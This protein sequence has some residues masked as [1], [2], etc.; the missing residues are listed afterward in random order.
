MEFRLVY[1]G[2]LPSGRS[3]GAVEKHRIREAL[4]P[5][6][7]AL[8]ARTALARLLNLNHPDQPPRDPSLLK[9]VGRVRFLPVISQRLRL[10]AHVDI[11]L[12]RP[13]GAGAV[14]TSGGDLDNRLKTLFDAL[15]MPKD[16]G[17][18]TPRM[19]EGLGDNLFYCLLEDDALI[20]E[21]SVRADQLL[22]P[23]NQDDVI[24]LILV[25]LRATEH[26]WENQDLSS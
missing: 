3:A 23:P 10:V 21:V 18:L 25:R 19:A 11:T 1:Q 2:P 26:T 4:Q 16:A 12:L 7:K 24:A 15:R 22:A 14:I 6:L 20:T 8:W 17:E 13:E 5:Q 9:T